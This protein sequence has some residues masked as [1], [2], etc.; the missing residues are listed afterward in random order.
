MDGVVHA[1]T[2]APTERN[3]MHPAGLRWQLHCQFI[4]CYKVT[5]L[6]VFLIFVLYSCISMQQLCPTQHSDDSLLRGSYARILRFQV[7][8]CAQPAS[9]FGTARL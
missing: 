4:V 9:V 2:L 1:G 3:C 8:W 7:S 5:R 6:R